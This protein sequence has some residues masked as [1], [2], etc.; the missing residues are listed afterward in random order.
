MERVELKPNP[1]PQSEF[2][3]CGADI[4][5]F[6]GK[7]GSGKSWGLLADPLRHKDVHGFMAVT[8]RRTRPEITRAGSLWDTSAELYPQL[9]AEPRVSTLSWIWPSGSRHDFGNLEHEQDLYSWQGAQIAQLQFD[10]LTT[11]TKKQFLFLFSRNRTTCGVRPCIRATCNPDPDSWVLDLVRWYLDEKG[12][13]DPKKCGIIRWL[14]VDNGV[15]IFAKTKA[16]LGKLYPTKEPKSFTFIPGE[17]A[18]QLGAEY[19]SNLDALEEHDRLR[20]KEGN[21]FARPRGGL[22]DRSMFA[23]VD[24]VPGRVAH[25]T[26]FW[27]FAAT[28]EEGAKDPDFTAAVKTASLADGTYKVLDA[29]EDR[30]EPEDAISAFESTAKADGRAVKVA[31][32][33]EGGSSGKFV[34]ASLTKS[35]RGW[36]S[37][38]IRSTGSKLE[39]AK[40]ALAQVRSKK[41]APGQSRGGNVLLLRGPWNERFLQRL[42]A[43]GGQGHD[44]M[45]DAFH[46]S[47]NDCMANTKELPSEQMLVAPRARQGDGYGG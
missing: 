34:S 13:P 8:F 5:L 45:A 36:H 39:R 27:D 25:C 42:E 24:K 21:W 28:K 11:F 38:G 17:L 14:I 10:E 19:A 16:E 47:F 7:A 43:F 20:L 3:S 33:E 31:W 32:E 23:I 29:F 41:P 12:Y 9:G 2:L 35:V 46:G 18:P 22:Y 44:D 15:F 4:I 40:P 30:W 26:R 1:G 37:E 6:G